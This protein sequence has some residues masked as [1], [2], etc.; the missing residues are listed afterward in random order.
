MKYIGATS[1]Y[2]R[3]GGKPF[4]DIEFTMETEVNNQ[5]PFSSTFS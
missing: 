5:L 3:G 2:L 4:S 1:F